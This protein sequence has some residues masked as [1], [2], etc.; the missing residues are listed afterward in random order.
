MG[1]WVYEM[2]GTILIQN[3]IL[4]II[5][6]LSLQSQI[7]TDSRLTENEKISNPKTK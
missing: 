5:I 7:N 2:M 6:F 4:P 3:F 1:N